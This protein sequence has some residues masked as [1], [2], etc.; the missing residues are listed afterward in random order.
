MG[1]V[2]STTLQRIMK[3][4]K[5]VSK[6]CHHVSVLLKRNYVLRKERD[7][8]EEVKE[9]VTEVDSPIRVQEPEPR[10]VT[11]PLVRLSEKIETP[12]DE[13][14][15]V[16]TVAQAMVAALRVVLETEEPEVAVVWLPK[17]KR[18]RVSE[19]RESGVEVEMVVEVDKEASIPRGLK[20]YV[21]RAPR[22]QDRYG[23]EVRAPIVLSGVMVGRGVVSPDFSLYFNQSRRFVG[24]HEK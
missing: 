11:K 6:L 2:A 13:D 17:G 18:R 15:W 19:D 3:L 1:L 22:G 14:V 9:A 7:R 8:Q 12:G 4:E 21:A 23:N 24:E 20:C 16:A 10:I 5:E